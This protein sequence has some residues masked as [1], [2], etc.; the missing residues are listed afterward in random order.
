MLRLWRYVALLLAVQLA[1]ACSGGAPAGNAPAE[2]A[3]RPAPRADGKLVLV[4]GDS[5][6]AGYRLG[7]NEGFA[8]ALERA[9]NA[10]GTPARVVNGGV[11]GD[12]TAAGLQR[13]AFTLD[14]LERAPDLVI[15]GLGGNDALRGLSA[16]ETRRN[17]AAI[18]TELQRRRIR[19]MLTGMLAPRNMGPDY[20]A[21]FDPIFPALARQFGAE[22]YPF[23][24]DGLVARPDLLLDDGMHPNARGIETIVARIAPRVRA[25]LTEQ[26]GDP[27]RPAAA[28]RSSP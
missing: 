24:L 28:P 17:L 23:F 11:S 25:E 4:F 9:L 22:L 2:T 16:V 27:I 19:P 7:P 6:Y 8:P 10:A 14:G 21:A 15:V 26:G 3:A 5:L 20:A 13:L 12:T 1:A 18:L